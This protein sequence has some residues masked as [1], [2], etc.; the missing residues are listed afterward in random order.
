[1]IENM[2]KRPIMGKVV[3]VFIIVDYSKRNFKNM[4]NKIII[5]SLIFFIWACRTTNKEENQ[6][7]KVDNTSILSTGD[8][9]KTYTL[10]NANGMEVAIMNMGGTIVKWTAPDKNGVFADITLGSNNPEDY[11]LKTKYFGAIIGRFANRIG[12]GKFSI[13]NKEYTLALNDGPNTVHGGQ[14]G[15]NTA[16]WNVTAIKTKEPS[17]KLNYVSKDGQEGYPGNLNMEVIYTLKNDNS[18]VIDYQATTDKTTII[19]LTNHAYFNLKGEGN[20]DILDHEITI[21][22][23]KYLPTDAGLIPTGEI[24]AVAGTPFD[25]LTPHI[26]GKRINDKTNLDIK[27]GDGYDHCWIFTDQ[28]NKLKLVAKVKELISGRTMEVLTTEPA[29]QFYTGNFLDGTTTGKAGV[30]YKKRNGL[31]LETQHFPDSP[32]HNNFP[33]TILKPG[34]TYKTTTIYKFGVE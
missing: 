34:Q 33:S 17:L 1:M 2:V 19:N 4:K 18:L 31:C 25:F 21:N 24:K 20:G 32:N 22:A 3:K 14:Y 8:S 26:I 15:F 23:N 30:I 6:S 13:D 27:L 9:V 5:I 10:K 12:K 7:I 29:V 28:S 16:I 11:L